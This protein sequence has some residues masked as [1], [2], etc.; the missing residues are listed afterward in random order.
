MTMLSVHSPHNP[1]TPPARYLNTSGTLRQR[2]VLAIDD[3]LKAVVGQLKRQGL[4]DS[5]YVVIT[6]DQGLAFGRNPSKGVPYEGS[7]RVPLVIKGPSVKAGATLHQI[8]NLADLA[9]TFLDWMG[10]PAMAVDGRSLDPLLRGSSGSWRQA[11]PITHEQMSSAPNV[12]TWQGVRTTQYAYW[13]YQGGAAQ[14][15]D[16][17]KDAGQTHNIAGASPTLTQ[18]LAALSAKLATCSGAACRSL[19]DQGVQ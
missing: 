2:T 6:S 5:T 1:L 19:E 7:I 4:Y 10:A 9:P 8:V 12:P 18:K 15:Y 17:T 14:L 13:K 16:M 3:A 11:M